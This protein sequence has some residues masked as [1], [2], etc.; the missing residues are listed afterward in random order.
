MDSGLKTLKEEEAGLSFSTLQLQE[1]TTPSTTTFNNT[2][3][4]GASTVKTNQLTAESEYELF[5]RGSELDALTK[6]GVAAKINSFVIL[7]FRKHINYNVFG[8]NCLHYLVGW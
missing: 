6:R 4:S 5:G 7:L 8:R 1:D 2:S 3:S